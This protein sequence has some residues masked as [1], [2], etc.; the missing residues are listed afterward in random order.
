MRGRL[1]LEEGWAEGELP[2][3]EAA[4]SCPS[5]ER[6]WFRGGLSWLLI[7]GSF[8]TLEKWFLQLEERFL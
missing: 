2:G 6:S 3:F 8:L 1:G 7:E 4:W 5:L